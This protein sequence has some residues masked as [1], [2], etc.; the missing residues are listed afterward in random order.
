MALYTHYFYITEI[1]IIRVPSIGCSLGPNFV[2]LLNFGS[3]SEHLVHDGIRGGQVKC[4]IQA[5]CTL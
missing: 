5:M 2:I 4:H 1:G 3:Q